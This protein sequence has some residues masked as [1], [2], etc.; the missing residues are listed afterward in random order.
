[1]T[2]DHVGRLAESADAKVELEVLRNRPLVIA[3]RLSVWYGEKQWQSESLAILLGHNASEMHPGSG[4]L[5][6]GVQRVFHCRSPHARGIR[7]HH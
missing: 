4:P 6:Y 7:P 2:T 5:F 1:M 3:E